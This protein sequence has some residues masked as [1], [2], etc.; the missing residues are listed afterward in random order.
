MTGEAD[1]STEHDPSCARHGVRL[2]ALVWPA[3]GPATTLLT[4]LTSNLGVRGCRRTLPT[5]AVTGRV[6]TYFALR[7]AVRLISNVDTD[8]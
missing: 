1:V 7:D 6:V 5:S 4:Y 8:T 3:V 2:M